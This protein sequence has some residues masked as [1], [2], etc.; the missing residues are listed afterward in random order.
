M[1][2][3][4]IVL[5]LILAILV[6]CSKDDDNTNISN[7]DNTD[8]TTSDSTSHELTEDVTY[9]IYPVGGMAYV[10]V[11][12]MNDDT[13]YSVEQVYMSTYEVTF[14]KAEKVRFHIDN[15]ISLYN[16]YTL[17]ITRKG[18]NDPDISYSMPCNGYSQ[19]LDKD[20]WLTIMNETDYLNQ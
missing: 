16:D 2:K 15:R 6:S 3:L 14:T 9:L 8:D 18:Y 13:L 5:V 4:T 19:H 1:K 12:D 7:V 11:L 10:S 20:V 17:T